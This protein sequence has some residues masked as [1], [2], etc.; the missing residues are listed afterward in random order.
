MGSCSYY[1]TTEGATSREAFEGACQRNERMY[2]CDYYSG[3]MN[4][5]NTPSFRV[6]K[7]FDTYKESNKKEA[8]KII[9]AKN[10]GEMG[11]AS[12]IDLGVKYW[13]VRSVKVKTQTPTATRKMS[14]VVC[15]LAGNTV[16][17]AKSNIFDTMKGAREKLERIVLE[18]GNDEY[19]I[20]KKYVV[21]SGS[22]TCA[23]VE[24]TEKKVKTKPK[25]GNAIPIHEYVIFGFAAE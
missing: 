12:V 14:F 21:L 7:T 6:V 18:T 19:Q 22:E 4:S 9:T 13:V 25:K 2:G 1:I 15:D 10:H 5:A 16:R 3:R 24:L 20:K 11:V 17:P 8:D 23:T